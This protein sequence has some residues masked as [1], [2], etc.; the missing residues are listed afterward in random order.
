LV[1]PNAFIRK[2]SELISRDESSTFTDKVSPVNASPS[3]PTKF[4]SSDISICP[5]VIACPDKDK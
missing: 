3:P 2:V 5:N 4:V 1:T